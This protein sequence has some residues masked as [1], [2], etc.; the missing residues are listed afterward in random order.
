MRTKDFPSSETKR[1]PLLP[2]LLGAAAVGLG[3]A[4]PAGLA[5]AFTHPPKRRHASNPRVIG[6]RHF[7]IRLRTADE[8]RLSAWYVPA[9]RN[10][11]N[12]LRPHGVVV[13]CHGYY[14][15]RGTMLPYLRFLHEAGYATLLFDF[16]AHGWSGGNVSTIGRQEIDDLRAALDWVSSR[17]RLQGLPLAVLGES[18]GASVALMTAAEDTRI[19]AVVSDSAFAR[20]DAAV[21]GRLQ[22]LGPLAPLVTPPT[23][24]VGERWF[25]WRCE[26]VAPEEAIARIA[27]RPVLLIHGAEDR[28]IVPEHAHR[29]LRAA[30]GN[31]TLWEVPGAAHCRSVY[32]AGPEYARRVHEFLDQALAPPSSETAPSKSD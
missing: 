17:R 29:L 26:E 28:F 7:R 16:R 6:I 32:V 31:A 15:N 5:W 30:H 19:Q 2:W 8:I 20:L 4:L 24:R 13:V 9:A 18:M 22:V 21:A 25:G 1:F 27:P 10:A 11:D 23:Q 12:R 14:G 3:A